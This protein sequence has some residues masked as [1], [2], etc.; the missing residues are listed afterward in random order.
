MLATA[1]GVFVLVHIDLALFGFKGLRVC[2]VAR[3]PG[4]GLGDADY[5][6]PVFRGVFHAGFD[7]CKA[8]AD[9]QRVTTFTHKTELNAFCCRD[10]VDS[11]LHND[12]ACCLF[13]IQIYTLYTRLAIVLL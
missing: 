10:V 9:A 12:L 6:K 13:L 7:G 3:A 11:Y 8:E 1:E 2:G 4:V 5:F